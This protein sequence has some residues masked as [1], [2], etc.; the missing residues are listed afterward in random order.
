[1]SRRSVI[2][3]IV[4]RYSATFCPVEGG[5]V[6]QPMSRMRCA[7]VRELVP[8]CCSRIQARPLRAATEDCR[9]APTCLP[10]ATSAR[11][12]PSTGLRFRRARRRLMSTITSSMWEARPPASRTCRARAPAQ[13]EDG[14]PLTT[15]RRW[16]RN[17]SRNCFRFSSR[18]WPSTSATCSCRSAGSCVSFH[19]RFR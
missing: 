2:F 14:A 1:M 16:R 17:A 13:L 5:E 7:D 11:T 15:S 8:F 4:S 19:R 3:S 18:G 9:F 10:R 12:A 6:L